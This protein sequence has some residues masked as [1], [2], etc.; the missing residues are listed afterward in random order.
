[1]VHFS[2]TYARSPRQVRGRHVRSE[3]AVSLRMGR[4]GRRMGA[5]FLESCRYP[6]MDFPYF[7]TTHCSELEVG[8]LRS[9]TMAPTFR[10]KKKSNSERWGA[11]HR[12]AMAKP[13][14]ISRAPGAP[15]GWARACE[16]CNPPGPRSPLVYP[17]DVVKAKK[18]A[19]PRPVLRAQVTIF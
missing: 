13:G 17:I 16:P 15:R 19:A 11:P 5:S 3:V 6:P 12:F 8:D 10:G 4:A 1:M 9:K 14:G 2:G 7:P 18:P